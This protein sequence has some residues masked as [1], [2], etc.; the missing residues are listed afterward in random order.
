MDFS[1]GIITS[2]ENNK[3]LKEIINSIKIQ[4]I[5]N[6]EIIIVGQS[7]FST[8]KQE[9]IKSIS[10]DENVRTGWITKKKNLI[11]DNSS[12]EN[13]VY[14]HDYVYLDKNWYKGYKKF[15]NNF[16]VVTNKIKNYDNTRFR[17]WT[18]WSDNDN[19]VDKIIN[20][21]LNLLLPY[22]VDDLTELMYISGTYWIAKKEIMKKY[23]L[24]EDLSWGEGEDVEWSKRVREDI[25]FQ[26]N[27][28]STVKF[29][30]QKR[31]DFNKVKRK[32][33][34]EI[35]KINQKNIK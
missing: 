35:Y 15:G 8:D 19:Q 29:L 13:I 4:K 20:K 28:F 17:D 18:L 16:K 25:D 23:P 11:T 12:Y 24:D 9:K 27:K 22:Y 30:K 2:G 6:Y 1:F 3:F 14:L 31:N 26:F 32:Q 10:F 5:D 34:R 21:N 33:L 7:S